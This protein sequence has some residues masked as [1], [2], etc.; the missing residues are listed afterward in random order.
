MRVIIFGL[1]GGTWTLLRPAMEEGHMPFLQ[2][3]V[4][5]GS[6]GTLRSTL[7]AI[8]PAAWSS[9]LTGQSVGQHGVF[10]F[11]YVDKRER[12]FRLFNAQMLPATVWD[13]ASQHGLTVGA[14]NVPMMYPPRAVRGFVVSGLMTPSVESP[15]TYPA[16]LKGRLL[17]QFPDYDIFRQQALAEIK[18]QGDPRSFVDAMAAMAEMRAQAGA[19]LI[20]EYALDLFMIHFQVM[21]LL[22]HRLWW[23]LDPEQPEYDASLRAH[24][25]ERFLR[26]VDAAMQRLAEEFKHVSEKPVAAMVVSDHGMQANRRKFNL[27]NLLKAEGFLVPPTTRT[28]TSM[29]FEVG[30][31]LDVLQVRRLL[32]SRVRSRTATAVKSAVG[33]ERRFALRLGI[34]WQRSSAVAVGFADE[35]FIYVLAKEGSG[36]YHRVMDRLI[37]LLKGVRDPVGEAPVV[38]AVYHREEAF[39][40]QAGSHLPDLVVVPKPAYACHGLCDESGALFGDV[41]P[42]VDVHLGRH[43]PEG[44]IVLAGPGLPQAG[45]LRAEMVDVAPTILSL[46]GLAA[47]KDMHGVALVDDGGSRGQQQSAVGEDPTAVA[48]LPYTEEEQREVEARLRDLGYL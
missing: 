30:R 11:N 3:L 46:L 25:G 29:V 45:D 9:F 5:Q 31:R 33:E 42:G 28:R 8:T 22:Q 13:I 47:T 26:P 48:A 16:E 34:D 15:F 10:D 2:S 19:W 44:V 1:D 7:P 43:H 40:A 18:V 35:G 41:Q 36:A 37:S 23:Y 6:S 17:T 20:R 21:D 12:A 14:L 39:E 4:D 27:G 24:V 38:E 32:P